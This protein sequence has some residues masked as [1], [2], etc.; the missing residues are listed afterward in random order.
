VTI[1]SRQPTECTTTM[2]PNSDFE[3]IV[4]ATKKCKLPTSNQTWQ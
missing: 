3:S 4:V 2:T 1:I